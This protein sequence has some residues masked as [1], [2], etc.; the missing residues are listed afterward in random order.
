MSEREMIVQKLIQL[1][2]MY[3]PP[4][5][6]TPGGPPIQ[7][8]R[9]IFI[10]V[11]E[12]PGFPFLG[13]L[14]GPR[15]NTKKRLERESNCRVFIRGKGAWRDDRSQFQNPNQPAKPKNPWDDEPL[16]VFIQGNNDDDVEKCEADVMFL[17]DVDSEETQDYMK[18]QLRE[19]HQLNGTARDD[20][21]HICGEEGHRQWECP[22][23]N[24]KP[25]FEHNKIK[26]IHCGEVSHAS[27]DCPSKG[28]PGEVIQAMMKSKQSDAEY[29]AFLTELETGKAAERPLAIEDAEGEGEAK[30]GDSAAAGPSKPAAAAAAAA[31]APVASAADREV[32]ITGLPANITDEELREAFQLFGKIEECKITSTG[33]ATII[34]ETE[35]GALSSIEGLDNSEV[36]GQTIKVNSKKEA[37][38]L[39]AVAATGAQQ[40]QQRMAMMQMQMRQQMMQ[41][42]AVAMQMMRQRSAMMMSMQQQPAPPYG[43]PMPGMHGPPMMAPPMMAPPMMP[44]MMPMMPMPGPPMFSPPMPG[45]PPM[46]GQPPP[47]YR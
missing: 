46:P 34:M 38:R 24:E 23:K 45:Y 37:A 22:K 15:G 13:Q 9:K 8:T 27:R 44:G 3:Q 2:P 25:R 35:D 33:S 17:L 7:F 26:C 28:K 19:L 41:R 4:A 10:P 21:C 20:Y 40:N 1:N 43:A 36:S 5:A 30:A 11:K 32:V 29:D 12:H 6:G 39:A 14:I 42:Q 31:P 16:H 18:Q 47:Q